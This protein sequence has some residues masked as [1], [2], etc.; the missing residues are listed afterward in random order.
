MHVCLTLWKT[1]LRGFR[2]KLLLAAAALI[3]ICVIVGGFAAPVNAAANEDPDF[4]VVGSGAG[5]GP[6]AA[7]LARRGFRVLLLEAGLDDVHE[8]YDY[9]VPILSA[10]VSTENPQTLWEYYVR[11]YSDDA[12][13]KKDH[14]AQY[15]ASGNL[16]GVWYPRAATLGGSVVHNFLFAVTPHE[17]DWD[18]IAQ[19]TGDQSWRS[20]NMRKY[21]QRL[22]ANYYSP[23]IQSGAG[24]GYNGWLGTTI[25]DPNFFLKNDP[26]ITRNLL[27]AA[28]MFPQ[29]SEAALM[30]SL[31]GNHD[32]LLSVL[33]RDLNSGDAGRDS[34]EG[35]F[36]PT[37]HIRNG[38]R[39]TPREFI[40]ETVEQGYPLT[41][42][43][44]AFV[45]KVLFSG[46]NNR[47]GPRARGV[48]YI[49][50]AHV[51]QADTMATTV[52]ADTPRVQVR[53]RREVILSAGTFNT[54][55]L[56]KLSGIG[57]AEELRR[58][59][60]PVL[61]NSPGVGR[62]MQ[63]RY[64]VGI[65]M[66]AGADYPMLGPCTF[67]QTPDDPCLAQWFQ[68]AGL[69]N[70]V[71]TAGVIAKRSSTADNADSDLLFYGAP[72]N[73]RGYFKGYT[74][75]IAPNARTFT[76][77]I[78]KAHTR[79]TAGTV[80]LR[81]ANP[82]ERP[83]INFRYFHEGT[84][85]NAADM[86]DLE[87]MVEGVELVRRITAK[88]NELMQDAGGFKEIFPGPEVDTR[89]EIRQFIRDNA[90][91]HHASSTAAIGP[92]G[93]PMAV[94]DSEFRVRGTRGLRVVDASVFPKIPG[95]FIV[96]PIF[97]AS[98]KAADVIAEEYRGRR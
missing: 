29:P 79:N 11:H 15:D 34:A 68:S 49:D 66:E 62:N 87:A 43:T 17:S 53:A 74:R 22:E 50:R 5:G 76:W 55:Q 28:L 77:G 52:D 59:N 33:T 39:V 19:L 18:Y 6:L 57:P 32:A 46:V 93:D 58:F 64:E 38:K 92:D 90:W 73:F 56:L 84:T 10:S 69:Y 23:T 95:T 8:R 13:Q 26:L 80:T 67:G 47:R 83:E 36:S 31:S 81:S 14:K 3:A 45:T 54:P 30:A 78:L 70:T 65:I 4:I 98:E 51:Y 75:Q 48:E 61:V 1:A 96:V 63:D 35:L 91:G 24:H 97:M 21:F 2:I 16:L 37:L 72:Y 94:L 40:V 82:L 44:G 12:Q 9:Q 41:V 60:I 88:T 89:E 27:A 7:N 25:F 42:K 71:G 86:K 85:A 20:H